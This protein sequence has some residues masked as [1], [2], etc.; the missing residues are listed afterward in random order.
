MLLYGSSNRALTTAYQQAR[1][2]PDSDCGTPTL[3]I[4]VSEHQFTNALSP[5]SPCLRSSLPCRRTVSPC[6]THAY[7]PT[8]STYDRRHPDAWVG[9][10]IVV[11]KGAPTSV[12]YYASVHKHRS[13]LI[14]VLFASVYANTIMASLN[15]RLS[16]KP[17]Q[18][19]VSIT[20][21]GFSSMPCTPPA[22]VNSFVTTVR[23]Q[24]FDC[25]CNFSPY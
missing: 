22:G 16:M 21:F 3:S 13:R 25:H 10:L 18:P 19:T 12:T 1:Q 5:F 8:I 17:E 4:P 14:L 2:S 7:V 20:D 23:S 24:A 11:P 9:F 6:C 15:G